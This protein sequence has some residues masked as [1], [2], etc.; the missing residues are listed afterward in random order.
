ME[1]CLD[2]NFILSGLLQEREA[3][4]CETLVWQSDTSV[5]P[6]LHPSLRPQ[7]WAGDS[8]VS[9]HSDPALLLIA[10]YKKMGHKRGFKSACVFLLASCPSTVTRSRAPL[11][12]FSRSEK[13]QD[14][15]STAE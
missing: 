2:G 14:V 10:D 4:T 12:A 13:V 3:Q 11:V 1:L 9:F 8:A 5:V 15:E 6:V 7:H